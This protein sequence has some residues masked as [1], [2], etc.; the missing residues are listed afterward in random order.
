MNI[1][2]RGK[3]GPIVGAVAGAIL[4]GWTAIEMHDNPTVVRS[5]VFIGAVV[6]GVIAGFVVRFLDRASERSLA[7]PDL[8]LANENC[9]PKCG[10]RNDP[11][12]ST[13]IKCNGPLVPRRQG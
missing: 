8:D 13:C 10:R 1:A 2:F 3:H 6:A 7:Q 4:G 11:S 9:C 12:S 5:S